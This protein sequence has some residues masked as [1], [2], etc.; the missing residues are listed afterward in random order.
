MRKWQ[1]E[2]FKNIIMAKNKLHKYERV[3]HLPNVTFSVLG[4]S[5]LPTTYPWYDNR[6]NGMEKILELGCGKGEYSLALATANPS[7]LCVGIDFKSHRICVG[8]EKAIARG[9]ENVLFFCVRIERIKEFFVEHSIHEIW[10]TFPDPHPKN[11]T[12]KSRLSAPSFLAA[13]A[14]LLIPGGIVHLKTDSELFYNFTLES[15]HQWGGHVVSKSDNIHGTDCN[16][17]GTRDIVSTFEDTALSKGLTIK[18]LA[19]TLN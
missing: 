19:F 4:E 14:H 12:I 16:R 6:Y 11:R 8:A 2:F 3:Q 17:H 15:V 18:Y 7:K 5:G 9:L 10:L 13:Y 1:S